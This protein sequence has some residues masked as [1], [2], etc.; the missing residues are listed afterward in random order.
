MSAR[1]TRSE[2]AVCG[3]MAGVH[4]FNGTRALRLCQRVHQTGLLLRRRPQ[5]RLQN[6]A[7]ADRRRTTVLNPCGHTRS[8]LDR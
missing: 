4:A 5:S 1:H 3:N 2:A 8:K 7:T 6:A